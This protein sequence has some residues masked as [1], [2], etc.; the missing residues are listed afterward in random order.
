[1]EQPDRLSPWLLLTLLSSLIVRWQ[2]PSRQ[3]T[4]DIIDTL[5][6]LVRELEIPLPRSANQAQDLVD[7][8]RRIVETR[9]ALSQSASELV[10]ALD[11]LDPDE[12]Q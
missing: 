5:G 3:F 9:A 1:M 10:T 11:H 6:P 4:Q 7:R 2:I 12:A 8:C